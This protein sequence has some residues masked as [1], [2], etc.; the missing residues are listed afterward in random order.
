M[1]SSAN[2]DL[3]GYREQAYNRDFKDKQRFL[4][5]LKHIAKLGGYRGARI[6][7][8]GCGF[9]WQ[10]F[11]VS[12]LDDHNQV[13]GI[14]ILPSMIEGMSECVAGMYKNE[15]KFSLTPICADICGSVLE[16]K[17]FDSIYSIEAIEHVH[18]IDRMLERCY[19]LLRPDGTIILVN[20]N[21]ALNSK[22][23]D[24]IIAM[25]EKRENAWEWSNYLRGIRPIEH[26]DARPF[27]VMRQEI[28]TAANPNLNLQEIEMV[29]AST[30]GLLK[31]EIEKI[32]RNYKTGMPLPERQDYDW[33]RNPETGEFAERLFD[34]FA[35]ANKMR[36]VGFKTQVQHMF[37]K[38]P[39]RLANSIQLKGFN[40]LMFNIR[41]VFIVFGRKPRN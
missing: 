25:W 14:D 31:Q 28:V 26:K 10:A 29:V 35:L 36:E 37:R 24:E 30:A 18:N 39:L 32:A 20:D 5:S 33:C 16:S 8:V 15:I 40:R 4:W 7:D 6:L 38:F 21:N 11:T 34:P 12:L 19:D 23:N 17:S 27:R 1:F 41:P 3:K 2:P 13:V 22:V 9:G